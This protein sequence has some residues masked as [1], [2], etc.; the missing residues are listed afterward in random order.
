MWTVE[1]LGP[2]AAAKL[3]FF[4]RTASIPGVSQLVLDRMAAVLV[5]LDRLRSDPLRFGAIQLAAPE[6]YF[7]S[8][9][10]I[11]QCA[12]RIEANP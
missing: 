7:E 6:H 4:D 2:Q 3:N 5:I 11:S 1:V 9:I 12:L 8:I 10:D